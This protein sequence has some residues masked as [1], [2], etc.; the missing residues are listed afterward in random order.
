MVSKIYLTSPDE[1][2]GKNLKD[3]GL[4]KSSPLWS[5][6]WGVL[7]GGKKSGRLPAWCGAGYKFI[8]LWL[9]WP[10]WNA[11]YSGDILVSNAAALR[12]VSVGGAAD[13]LSGRRAGRPAARKERGV[14]NINRKMISD[15]DSTCVGI[16]RAKCQTSGGRAERWGLAHLLRNW[17]KRVTLTRGPLSNISARKIAF[18][19]MEAWERGSYQPVTRD[20]LA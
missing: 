14:K 17:S 5:R 8:P 20:S 6:M 13:R 4:S 16:L 11:S 1:L 18:A 9:S 10:L 15:S 2:V 3:M 7:M 19:G 12:S